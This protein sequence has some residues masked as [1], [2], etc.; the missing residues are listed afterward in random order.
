MRIPGGVGAPGQ[1]RK[2]VLSELDDDVDPTT[3]SDV[4]VVV[5]ELVT[6]SVVHAD[7]GP[8]RTL[9]VEL[10]RLDDRLRIVVIDPG[11]GLEPP[12]PPA[13]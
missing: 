2:L 4:A 11:S 3:A 13:R 5:S 9:I 1:A 7:V 8:R 10:S 6:N 12:Y